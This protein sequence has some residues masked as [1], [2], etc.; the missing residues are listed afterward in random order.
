M[1]SQRFNKQL[2]QGEIIR[3]EDRGNVFLAGQAL[4][5]AKYDLGQID[6]DEKEDSK[7][8][9]KKSQLGAY[10]REAFLKG[11]EILKGVS[12]F[13]DHKSVL[14]LKLPRNSAAA[15]KRT[16]AAL[17]DASDGEKE[18]SPDSAESSKKL[19]RTKKP[20]AVRS[21]LF[22]EVEFSEMLTAGAE[23]HNSGGAIEEGDDEGGEK[24]E[25]S[26]E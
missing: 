2:K 6:S 16:A 23:S 9:G 4:V 11:D 21:S 26:R 1:C 13:E 19:K 22:D 5:Q 14:K 12:Q 15:K 25:D 18:K 8:K 10:A 17:S 3:V 20:K 24:A 7:K